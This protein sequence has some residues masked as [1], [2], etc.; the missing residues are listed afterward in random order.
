MP[1]RLIPVNYTQSRVESTSRGLAA[2]KIGRAVALSL[3]V[4]G[5]RYASYRPDSVAF[6]GRIRRL[7]SSIYTRAHWTD[8]LVGARVAK[9]G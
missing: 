2:R 9:C 1:S 5:A 8:S 3:T 6:I 4:S 7:R